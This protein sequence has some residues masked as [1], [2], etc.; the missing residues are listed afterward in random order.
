MGYPPCES[1]KEGRLIGIPKPQKEPRPQCVIDAL[2]EYRAKK[3]KKQLGILPEPQNAQSEI[4]VS[5]FSVMLLYCD[6]ELSVR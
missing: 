1:W 6:L 2:A 4:E 3:E 5:I